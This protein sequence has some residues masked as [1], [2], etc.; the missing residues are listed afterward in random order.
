LEAFKTTIQFTSATSIPKAVILFTMV[1]VLSAAAAAAASRVMDTYTEG[2][3][4]QIPGMVYCA[5][6]KAGDVVFSHASGKKGLNDGVAMTTDTI[7]WMASYTKLITSIACMQL[8]EQGILKLDDSSQ[9]ES[10]APE[11][12]AVKV[13]RRGGHGGFLLEEKDRRITLR[14]LLSHTGKTYTS[15]KLLPFSLL[16]Y[17]FTVFSWLWLC[18]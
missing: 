6:N 2:P 12:K 4:P 10:F 14:M 18:L 8:V 3:S 5:V 7:F 11:L 1:Q 15:A 13:L 9:L 16:N 17:L